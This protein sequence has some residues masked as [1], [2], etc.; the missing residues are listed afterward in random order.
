MIE[1]INAFNHSLKRQYLTEEGLLEAVG[2]YQPVIDEYELSVEQG[3]DILK[4]V[5]HVLF[6]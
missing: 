2:A 5:Y 1:Q 6:T 4:K 3:I